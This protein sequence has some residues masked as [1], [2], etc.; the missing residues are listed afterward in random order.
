MSKFVKHH[1]KQA[2]FTL[3]EIMY[4]LLIMGAAYL[5][6]SGWNKNASS[7]NDLIAEQSNFTAIVTAARGLR[8][9]GSYAS[10]TTAE[11]Q[12]VNAFA[13]MTG[14]GV[15][16]TPRSRWGGTVTVVGSAEQFVITYADVPATAC[17]PYVN[18][19]RESGMIV[20]PAP[21]CS[22]DTSTLA[23]IVR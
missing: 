9:A 18:G 1:A 11:L 12:R 7:K 2:G 17:S 15:G 23:F 19:I 21:E 16:Q 6:Y 10:V 8:S 13:A 22:G 5:A 14:S 20:E 3:T 4:V